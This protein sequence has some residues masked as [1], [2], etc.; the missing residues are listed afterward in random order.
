MPREK[1]TIER[2]SPEFPYWAVISIEAE[3]P[4]EWFAKLREFA[5]AAEKLKRPQQ[6]IL[7]Y[8]SAT[9]NVVRPEWPGQ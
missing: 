8:D 1:Q 4:A 6:G 3:T 9:V 2:R 5:D 7:L